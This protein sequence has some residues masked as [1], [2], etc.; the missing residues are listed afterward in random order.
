[1]GQDQ[2][3]LADGGEVV[4]RQNVNSSNLK[5]VGYDPKTKTLEIEFKSAATYQYYD[6]PK[7]EYDALMA[8]NSHGVYFSGYI[9][10]NYR[11]QRVN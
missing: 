9:K 3:K 1:L 8:A 2:R 10:P 4:D 6:V 11:W 5:S 7:S